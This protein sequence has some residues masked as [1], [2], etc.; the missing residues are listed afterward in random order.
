MRAKGDS[1]DPQRRQTGVLS[2]SPTWASGAKAPL[3]V[4]FLSCRLWGLAEG[5]DDR[6]VRGEASVM[7]LASTLATPSSFAG[8]WTP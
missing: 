6:R 5:A 7:S 4:S 8:P 3:A 2:R 1:R